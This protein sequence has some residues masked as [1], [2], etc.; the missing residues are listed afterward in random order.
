MPACLQTRAFSFPAAL[1]RQPAPPHL[2]ASATGHSSGR[3]VWW[4]LFSGWRDSMNYLS[5]CSG[6]EAATVAW[7]P[8]GWRPIAFSEI[9]KFPSA[10]L[11]HHYPNVTNLGD[12]TKYHEWPDIK[13]NLIVGGTPCQAFSV[14]G[15]RQGLSDPRGNLTLTFLGL[16]DRYRPEWVVWENVPG[17]LSDRT[18]AFGQ[19]LAGLGQLGYGWAYRMLDAQYFNVAQRRRRMFV[20]ANLG[21]WTRAAAVLFE[22]ESVLGNP[23][24]GREARKG[25]A[26]CLASRTQGGGG[27]GTYF[28]IG[29]GCIPI[30]MQAAAKNGAK[31]PNMMGVWNPGDPAPTVNASDR[32][33]VAHWPAEVAPPASAKSRVLRI[34]TRLAGRGCLFPHLARALTAKSQRN[35]SETETLLPVRQGGFFDDAK[36]GAGD[37]THALKAEGAD[38]SEDGTGRG[39]PIVAVPQPIAFSSKD[40]GAD[41]ALGISPTL[42][43]GGHTG[44]HANAS[45]PT[46]FAIGLQDDTTP[47]ISDERIGALHADAG[48]EGACVAY[49]IQERAVSENIQNGPS[50]KGCQEGVACTLEARHHVQA[51]AAKMAV[52]RLTPT[53]CERLQGFTT[54]IDR[55]V[56]DLCLDRQN[57]SVRVEIKCL[58]S[59]SSALRAEGNASSENASSAETTLWNDLESHASA[60]HAHVRLLHEP[61]LHAIHS[62]GRLMWPV[63]GVEKFAMSLR[64]TPLEDFAAALVAVQQE[65]DLLAGRGKAA[66]PQ[67]MTSFILPANGN[68]FASVFGQENEESASVAASSLREAIMFIISSLGQKTNTSR[69]IQPT[70]L[71]SALSVIASCIPSETP[72]TNS[73]KLIVD[74]E[75]DY[76]NIPWRKSPTAPDGPRYKA[77]GNSMAVPCMAWIGKRIAMVAAS[78]EVEF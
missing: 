2:S 6:I 65:A 33:A 36:C 19:F 51:V 26:P 72:I 17:V 75:R 28:D 44:S 45:A 43:A 12:M 42:R 50:G 77:L 31:S 58:R 24:P 69:L 10:V 74:V 3:Q 62:A 15:L 48:G 29:W 14:A 46:A 53:E 4:V 63:N 52:R 47:K 34:S 32:H 37:V 71:C 76:T 68:W 21:D 78:P 8:L 49:S 59:P 60:A 9:E 27:L 39:N 41:A 73:V 66:S 35:D 64:P 67:N 38:A 30:N 70:W 20:V 22:P 11:A 57:N 54:M 40:H 18:N 16:V 23:P 7:H 55:V 5:V 13:P 61:R 56:F 25:I 1:R